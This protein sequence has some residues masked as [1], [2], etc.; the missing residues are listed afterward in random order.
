MLR[1]KEI[2][3]G[4]KRDAEAER[5]KTQKL[6]EEM[7]KNHQVKLEN[8]QQ[9]SALQIESMQ[10]DMEKKSEEERKL[11]EKR[12]KD[13]QATNAAEMQK[14]RDDHARELDAAKK[15][16]GGGLLGDILG[17]VNPLAGV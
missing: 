4:A 16:S 5:L 6:I 2:I 13:L 15:S 10:A 9:E 3:E 1:Q 14:M 11:I 8:F 7:E 17:F 12:M